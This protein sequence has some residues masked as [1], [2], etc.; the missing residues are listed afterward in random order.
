MKKYIV[1]IK[2]YIIKKE[3]IKMTLEVSKIHKKIVY[4]FTLLTYHY[5]ILSITVYYL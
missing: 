4:N 2:I 5:I 1:Y 3:I